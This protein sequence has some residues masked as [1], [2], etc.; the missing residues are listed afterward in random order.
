VIMVVMVGGVAFGLLYA[1]AEL[2]QPQTPGNQAPRVEVYTSPPTLSQDFAPGE[3]AAGA[4]QPGF[5]SNPTQIPQAFPTST[6]PLPTPVPSP[7]L[8]PGEFVIGAQVQVVG[9]GGSGLNVRITPGYTGTPRFLAFDEEVFVLVDGPQDAD[10][11]EW[12]RIEDPN[13]P[14]RFGWAARNYLMVVS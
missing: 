9:V 4:P 3:G 13:D 5:G 7:S 6:V 10:G 8:P 1:V 11:L 12:W 14:S 2:S